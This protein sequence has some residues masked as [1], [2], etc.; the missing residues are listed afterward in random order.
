MYVKF[1]KCFSTVDANVLKDK[2]F[3]FFKEENGT[4]W[5]ILDNTKKFD[6]S[7]GNFEISDKVDC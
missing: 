2:G 4:H 3:E 7:Q 5:F 6:F 1:I